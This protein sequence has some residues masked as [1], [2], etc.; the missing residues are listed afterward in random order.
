MNNRNRALKR[1]YTDVFKGAEDY[2]PLIV[3]PPCPEAPTV[4]QMWNDLGRA[5]AKAASGF[6]PQAQVGSDWVPSLNVGLYQGIAISSLFGVEIVKLDEYEPICKSGKKSLNEF[7]KMGI[8][9][10]EG[11]VID[12]MFADVRIAQKILSEQDYL[13]SFPPTSSP[14]DLAQMMLGEEFLLSLITAP[15]AAKQF[16]FN[17]AEL[18]VSITE[19]IKS[20]MGQDKDEYIT[21]RGIFFPG[22]RLPCDAIVN[23][24]P[25]MLS[26]FVLPTLD[27]LGKNFGS[28]CIHF[29]TE[30]APSAHVLGVLLESD[31]IAAVDNWQ[32]PDAFLG[33]DAPARMQDKIA[34]LTDVDLTTPEKI[35][36]FL[37][38]EPVRDVPRKGGRGMVAATNVASVEEGK[39]VYDY[40]QKLMA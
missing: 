22:L 14:F 18:C 13:L 15:D 23:F 3:R 33:D 9:K 31:Y 35:D 20:E 21:N 17:L 24:S 26:E 12:R 6:E 8:P 34:I 4:D 10:I 5:V 40:W 16:L 11:P 2:I 36:E 28:L 25:A 37:S 30:P 7:L 39:K 29:C 32:G 38:R 27:I 1:L 19:M